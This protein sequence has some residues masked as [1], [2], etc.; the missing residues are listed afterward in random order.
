[1]IVAAC[2]D[3]PPTY[4]PVFCGGHGEPCQGSPGIGLAPYYIYNPRSLTRRADRPR[5]LP[6]APS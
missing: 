3:S 4:M 1:M 2:V 5:L 6:S